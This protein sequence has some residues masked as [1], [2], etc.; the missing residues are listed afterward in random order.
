MVV[1]VVTVVLSVVEV[2]DVTSVA[3]AVTV[4]VAAVV[5][6]VKAEVVAVVCVPQP[7]PDV[8][9]TS[10]APTI[11]SDTKLITVFFTGSPPFFNSNI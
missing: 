10:K 9:P 3:V 6:V 11:S 8:Q 5:T 4:V 1:F 7:A 2:A